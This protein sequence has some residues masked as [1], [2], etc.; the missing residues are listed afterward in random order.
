MENVKILGAGLSGLTAAINLSKAGHQ[1]DIFERNQDVGGRFN[2]D[3]QGLENW[4]EEEDVLDE[5]QRINLDINFDLDPFSQITATNNF[6]THKVVTKRPLFYLLKRGTV[7]GSMDLG[8]KRQAQESG[9]NIHFGESISEEDADI[10]ATGPLQENVVGMVK[11]ITFGSD[12]KDT[13]LMLFND[14]AGFKG[15]SYLLVTKGYGCLCIV[16]LEKFHNAD[17]CF[18]QAK[19]IISD[20]VNFEISDAKPCGG[21]GCFTLENTFQKGKT[22]FVGEAAGLQ[23]FLWG[24]GMRYALK[25]GYL[26]AQCIIHDEDYE[27]MAS[28]DFTGKLKAGMVNRYL[29]E[30]AGKGNYSIVI[31]NSKSIIN[32]LHWIS[33]YNMVHRILYPLALRKM[34]KRYNW[35]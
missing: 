18:T 31:N 34:K 15:Y 19:E 10:V 20:M 17:R 6:K 26:A 16:F 3:I 12:L 11:G 22:L 33:N 35:L 7:P 4:S 2:G 25:S 9:V 8:L 23:D 29:W 14:R 32:N 30:M 28:D 24:F 21:V 5:L 13:A 27:K 1:V